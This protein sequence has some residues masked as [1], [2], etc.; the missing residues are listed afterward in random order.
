MFPS[1]EIGW[2]YWLVIDG[3]LVVGLAGHPYQFG[4]VL[5]V[6][7]VQAVHFWIREGSADA[8]PVQ[9]RTGYLLLLVVGQWDPLY[10]IYWLQLVGTTVS[11]VFDYC[12][13]ARFLSLMPWNRRQPLSPRLIVNTFV[14]PPVKG[15]ILAGTPAV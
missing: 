6:G 14:S 7:A 12:I 15:S 5:A 3:L 2:W 4:P 1:R 10:F 8:F 9:V 13:F 11:I